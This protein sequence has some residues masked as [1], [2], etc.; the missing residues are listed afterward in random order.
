MYVCV[1]VCVCINA[2]VSL[3]VYDTFRELC[4]YVC[5][6]TYCVCTHTEYMQSIHT[7]Y[8]YTYIHT[9]YIYTHTHSFLP[10]A[11]FFLYIYIYIY[12]VCMYV[13]THTLILTPSKIFLQ[14]YKLLTSRCQGFYLYASYTHTHTHTY[15]YTYIHTHTS[16]CQGLYLYGSC[17]TPDP[18]CT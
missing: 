5:I 16:R 9:L 13:Y 6:H 7:Q 10:Q 3:L 18:P 8:V 11:N 4:M 14:P 17:A 2:V 1:C 12:N 15:I